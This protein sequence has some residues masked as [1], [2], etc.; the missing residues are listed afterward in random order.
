MADDTAATRGA[1]AP[2][3]PTTGMLPDR[4]AGA[5]AATVV[6]GTGVAAG[7][8]TGMVPDRRAGAWA[9]TAA[10]GEGATGIG[11]AARGMGAG[12][13]GRGTGGRAATEETGGADGA[14]AGPPTPGKP[15]MVRL[16]AGRGALAAA[17]AAVTPGSGGA[18]RLAGAGVG[19]DTP[20]ISEGLLAVLGGGVAAGAGRAPG[21]VGG[22]PVQ[23]AGPAAEP[24]S[25][26]NSP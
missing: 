17:G 19:G 1:G 6:G 22:R 9:A 8:T 18:S 10:G 14:W 2:A 12:A 15:M 11:G 4:R 24:R 21:Q 25:M 20:G 3:G 16:A 7:A 26:V 13:L 23:A 5:W